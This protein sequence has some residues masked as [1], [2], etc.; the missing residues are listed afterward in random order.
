M[1]NSIRRG[2]FLF[3]VFTAAA[4]FLIFIFYLKDLPQNI[5][6]DFRLTHICG[7]ML[8]FSVSV[9]FNILRVFF[10]GK[11][12]SKTFTFYDSSLFTLGGVLLALI[13]PFQA[14][15]MPFQ[16]YIM[17]KRSISPGEGSSI[18]ISRGLQ[19]VVVFIVTIPF[20]LTFFS[21][22]LTGSMVA[23]LIKYFL[24]LYSVL[25]VVTATVL[26]FTERIKRILT[27]KKMNVRLRNALFKVLDE[28]VNFKKAIYAMFTK[29]IKESIFSLI[30]TF[31]SL[32]AGFALTY[33]IVLMAKG[34][35]DFFLSFNIQFILTYLSAFVPTPGSSGV[36]EG[37]IALLYSQIVPKQQILLFIFLLRLVTT[38]I[39]ALLG[40][41]LMFGK[42]SILQEMK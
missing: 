5:S 31:I 1:K 22:L 19:S 17:S 3:V 13:T 11:I 2:I 18:L 7:I 40:L 42:K 34:S 35:T 9:V 8:L 37:G 29:G 24:M 10:L 32:Y 25:F 6:I 38:Y 23:N 20:T 21:H 28:V 30:C 26:S 12:F 33:F 14:G 15:G 4:Y 41:F 16:L 39:P 27:E 36:A